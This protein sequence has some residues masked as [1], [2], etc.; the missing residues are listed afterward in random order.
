MI[1]RAHTGGGRGKRAVKEKGKKHAGGPPP[2]KK[3][4]KKSVGS[5]SRHEIPKEK[6]NG[7][8]QRSLPVKRLGRRR[9]CHSAGASSN[10][11]GVLRLLNDGRNLRCG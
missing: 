3:K 11:V 4:K 10:H 8:V 5:L 7:Y 6:K 2:E 9:L 1:S